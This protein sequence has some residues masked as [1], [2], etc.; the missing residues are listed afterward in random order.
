MDSTVDTLAPEIGAFLRRF[1]VNGTI[2]EV[3]TCGCCYYFA[4]ILSERFG[5]DGAVIMYAPKDNHFG[6]M[7][8][9]L[10]YDITG[11]VTSEYE[12]IQWSLFDDDLERERII[13]DCIQ[14]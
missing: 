11:N 9:G 4:V 6:T 5:S 8:D 2:D 12:W 7:I 1:H 10:V 14:F 3:F 13:R